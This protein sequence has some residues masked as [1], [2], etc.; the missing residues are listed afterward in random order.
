MLTPTRRVLY[1]SSWLCSSKKIERAL[2]QLPRI[3]C[4]PELSPFYDASAEL[5]YLNSWIVNNAAVSNQ[6]SKIFNM[7]RIVL[8]RDSVSSFVGCHQCLAD[9]SLPCFYLALFFKRRCH[10]SICCER[11]KRC[12]C[13]YQVVRCIGV[14]GCGY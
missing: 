4:S 6:G 10:S 9:V 7:G 2:S 12:C 8:L 1:S 5:V 11:V 3:D 14:G 13:H